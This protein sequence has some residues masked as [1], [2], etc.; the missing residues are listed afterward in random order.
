MDVQSRMTIFTIS[1]ILSTP[2]KVDND[3]KDEEVNDNDDKDKEVDGNGKK[4]EEI[5]NKEVVNNDEEKTCFINVI[6]LRL[7]HTKK[8]RFSWANYP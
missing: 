2:T 3:N 1:S 7:L 5:S 8:A 6:S 4:Q